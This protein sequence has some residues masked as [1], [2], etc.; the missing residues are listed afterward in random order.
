[1]TMRNEVYRCAEC[2]NI[3]E[4]AHGA[5]RVLVCCGKPMN[6]LPEKSADSATMISPVFT[7]SEIAPHQPRTTIL[8]LPFAMR[9]SKSIAAYG[10]P[11]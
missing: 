11:I 10:D 2:G 8:A 1:M 7:L 6:L 5:G 4:V 9:D 3:V